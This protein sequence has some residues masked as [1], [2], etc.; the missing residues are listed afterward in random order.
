HAL[1]RAV[2][3]LDLAHVGP[4]DAASLRIDDDA[5]HAG[6]MAVEQNLPIRAVG[7]GGYHTARPGI[8]KKDSPLESIRRILG[9]H[10]EHR[11]QQEQREAFHRI[12]ITPSATDPGTAASE[13]LRNDSG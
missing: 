8:E 6:L 12:H 10:A 13:G 11:R 5:V 1:D 4:E 3:L 2:V 9:S 7:I